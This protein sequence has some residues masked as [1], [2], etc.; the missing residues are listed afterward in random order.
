MKISGVGCCVL[1]VLYPLCD[2][3]TAAA[4][5]SSGPGNGGILRGGASLKADIERHF[6][7]SVEQVLQEIAETA[8]P[9]KTL[10]GVAVASLI[11]ASQLLYDSGI[12]VVFY[13]NIADDENGDLIFDQI[14][15]T[16][17]ARTRLRRE[18]GR[19]PTTYIVTDPHHAD[20]QGERSF[21]AEPGV[22]EGLSVSLDDLDEG[23]YSSTITLFACIFWEPQ[24]SR[25]LTRVL[26]HCK[27][28]GSLTVVATAYDPSLRNSDTRWPIGDSDEVY[29]LT[30]VLIMDRDEAL[31]HS[32]SGGVREA[33]DFFKKM[34]VGALVVTNGRDPVRFWSNGAPLGKAEGIMPIA[35]VIVEDKEA[36]KLG[37]G[38][39]VDC[40]DNFV[41]GVLASL[42]LQMNEGRGLSL[43]EAVIWG[44][45]CGGFASTYQGG[46]FY[47]RFHGEKRARVMSYYAAYVRSLVSG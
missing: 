10:G 47:E 39:T 18:K 22:G 15:R 7:R 32:G 2:P 40:G 31:V 45:L 3:R 35:R 5:F 11:G 26:R 24:I 29:A 42:A 28:S 34:G 41:G 43:R 21:I 8:Q 46:T 20:G 36:G 25:D 1:D 4:Y 23:F 30:D 38:D 37:A 44:N 12:D 9:S 17:L 14:C 16:P 6:D 27:E 13:A 19:C 33:M